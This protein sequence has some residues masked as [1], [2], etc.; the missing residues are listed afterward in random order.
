MDRCVDQSFVDTCFAS[1]GA[2]E[3]LAAQAGPPS[4]DVSY[5]SGVFCTQT[6]MFPMMSIDRSEGR[7]P[8][9]NQKSIGGCMSWAQDDPSEM[10]AVSGDL[11]TNS[12]GPRE[13]GALDGR[14]TL[15]RL[16]SL[17]REHFNQASR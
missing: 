13:D 1:G 16:V 8:S 14:A 4:P 15:V 9:G 3:S 10:P 7:T 17:R 6:E 5:Q 12:A 11:A 2:R